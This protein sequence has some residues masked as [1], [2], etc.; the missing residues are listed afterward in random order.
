MERI[1]FVDI[2]YKILNKNVIRDNF[3]KALFLDNPNILKI[4]RN[5]RR[6]YV[7]LDFHILYS[8]INLISKVKSILKLQILRH[9]YFSQF[10][11]DDMAMLY[12]KISNI[13]SYLKNNN[14][15][16]TDC[17]F[18]FSRFSARYRLVCLKVFLVCL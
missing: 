14:R 11:V 4:I 16:Q 5:D 13:S 9:P 10:D 3:K 8:D 17:F 1:L 2:D 7:S 12:K 6:P 15:L 18:C